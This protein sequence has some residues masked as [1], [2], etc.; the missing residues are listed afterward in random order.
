LQPDADAVYIDQIRK[1][2]LYDNIWQAFAVL[3]PLKTVGVTGDGRTTNTSSA[4][5]P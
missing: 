4:S 5:A 2:G 3:P 1:A